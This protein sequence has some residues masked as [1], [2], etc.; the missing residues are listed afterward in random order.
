MIICGKC[1]HVFFSKNSVLYING[2]PH[3]ENCLRKLLSEIQKFLKAK[4]VDKK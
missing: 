3:C 4:G 2:V 1:G